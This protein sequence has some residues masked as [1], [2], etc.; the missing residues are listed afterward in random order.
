MINTLCALLFLWACSAAANS[1]VQITHD[2]KHIV[3]NT[4]LI[5]NY[6]TQ[7][8]FAALVLPHG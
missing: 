4:L 8:M 2:K 3:I 7:A 6:I 1:L 5:I